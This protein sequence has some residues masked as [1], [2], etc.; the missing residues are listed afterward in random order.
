MCQGNDKTGKKGTDAI[1]VM[2]PKDVPNITKDQP[3]SYAKVVVAYRPQKDD[4][5]KLESQLEEI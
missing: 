4:P 2:D 3:P 5:Y 1:F